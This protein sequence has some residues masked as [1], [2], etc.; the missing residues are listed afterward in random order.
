MQEERERGRKVYKSSS[1]ITMIGMLRH[2][3]RKGE[4]D[5]KPVEGVQIIHSTKCMATKSQS[6]YS[7]N[8]NTNGAAFQE[9]TMETLFHTFFI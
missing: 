9:M 4:R 3:G 1:L 7:S 8:G 5:E 2:R 6:S